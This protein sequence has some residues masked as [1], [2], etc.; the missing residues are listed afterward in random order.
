MLIVYPSLSLARRLKI[1]PIHDVKKSDEHPLAKWC[2]RDFRL[3]TWQLL[4]FTNPETTLSIVM[5]AAP[6]NTLTVRFREY[7]PTYLQELGWKEAQ[8]TL[9]PIFTEG[10]SYRKGA[11]R[12]DT[13]TMNRILTDLEAASA[14]GHLKHRDLRGMNVWLLELLNGG[15][16]P[17]G[18]AYPIER[19][20]RWLGITPEPTPKR[21]RLHLIWPPRS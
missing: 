16:R 20:H 6:Y 12:S 11:S 17:D 14:C 2:A 13:G 18:Y 9:T 1:T 4:L 8:A 10:T 7:A 3:G 19:F 15:S 21:R 5:E